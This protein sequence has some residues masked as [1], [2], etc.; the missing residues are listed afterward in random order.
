MRIVRYGRRADVARLLGARTGRGRDEVV[1]E[2]KK[3]GTQAVSKGSNGERAR[4][5]RRA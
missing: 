5:K 3:E 2:V 4:E 1:K